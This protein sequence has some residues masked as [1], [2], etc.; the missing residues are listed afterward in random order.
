MILLVCEHFFIAVSSLIPTFFFFYVVGHIYTVLRESGRKVNDGSK[1]VEILQQCAFW[2]PLDELS[3][4]RAG[5]P[6]T[7]NY[8]PKWISNNKNRQ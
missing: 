8:D 5:N 1:D 2:G 6:K 3:P 7:Q 4:E